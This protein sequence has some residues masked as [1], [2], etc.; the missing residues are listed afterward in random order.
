MKNLALLLPALLVLVP[1]FAA[2]AAE[3]EDDRYQGPRRSWKQLGEKLEREKE[4][5]E[6]YDAAIY[7]DQAISE[8]ELDRAALKRIKKRM[9]KDRAA[10]KAA[11]KPPEEPAAA[12]PTPS[13]EPA[14][15]PA[16]DSSIGERPPRPDAP[17]KPGEYP[18]DFAFDF[19]VGHQ[20]AM[21]T[22]GARFTRNHTYGYAHN[23]TRI[24]STGLSVEAAARAW[25]D[26]DGY[27]FDLR[28]LAVRLKAGPFV[29]AVGVQEIAWG[30]TF[31]QPI[32]DIVNPRD[33]R[34]P[35]MLDM[36]WL[37]LP[38]FCANLKLLFESFRLQ[39]VATPY[40]RNNTVP[41][42]KSPFTFFPAQTA[43]FPVR[44]QK[45]FPLTN[46]GA[47][48]EYGGR[49]SFLFGFGLD[50]SAFYFWHWNRRPTYQVVVGDDLAPAL[51]PVQER[52]HSA[53][54]S[55]SKA[56]GS[57]VL[58][59]DTAVHVNEPW[60]TSDPTQIKHITHVQAVIGLDY[61]TESQWMFGVQY[62][63]EMRGTDQFLNSASARIALSFFDGHLEP[64]IFAFIGLTDDGDRWIEPKLTWHVTDGWAVSVLA[65]FVWGSTDY[66]K[67]DLAPYRNKH[68]IFATLKYKF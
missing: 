59:G 54:L 15:E 68:R 7:F 67:G 37:R 52:I 45:D 11:P 18:L 38:V 10:L 39:V 14:P 19:E 60:Q 32:V 24:K 35:L 53:G 8:F 63:F 6:S 49:V 30:E 61:T 13:P 41:D 46:W 3:D 5:Q 28:A 40:P 62:H 21:L 23:V 12:V 55:F 43:G 44:P 22:D 36:D 34:D 65:D 1:T 20:S 9:E 58:R 51:Q 4:Q 42:A 64:E 33:F 50:V 16:E 57:L 2:L 25:A 27:E 26:P 48:G 47:D 31:G 29:A 17:K 56:F 66:L